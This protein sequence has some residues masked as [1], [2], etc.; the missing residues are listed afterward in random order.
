MKTILFQIASFSHKIDR[1]HV[2]LVLSLL[3]LALFVLGAGAPD[4]GGMFPK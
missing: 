1:R 4:D 2:Q 3:A